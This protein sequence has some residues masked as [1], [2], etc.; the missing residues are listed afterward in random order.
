MKTDGVRKLSVLLVNESLL[1]LSCNSGDS[2]FRVLL[3][4]Q[5][6]VKVSCTMRGL[7]FVCPLILL[8]SKSN[9][10]V[11]LSP[12]YCAVLVMD[13]LVMSVSLRFFTQKTYLHVH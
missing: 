6:P 12:G 13:P 9:A 5:M 4:F 1:L 8:I 3:I 11:F 2:V 10:E 7:N